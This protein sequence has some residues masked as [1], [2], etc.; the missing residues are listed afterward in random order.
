[1]VTHG[2]KLYS[3]DHI[4]IIEECKKKKKTMYRLNILNLYEN[5]I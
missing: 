3:A 2:Y 4:Q 1:M 5:K